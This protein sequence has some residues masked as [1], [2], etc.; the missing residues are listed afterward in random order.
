MHNRELMRHN[1]LSPKKRKYL[2]RPKA[3]CHA[4]SGSIAENACVARASHLAFR[5]MSRAKIDA[6]DLS[7]V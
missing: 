1:L 4:R 6:R 5:R 2:L 7:G 3:G